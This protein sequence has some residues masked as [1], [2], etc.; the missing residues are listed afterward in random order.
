M[1]LI[2]TGASKLAH[3]SLGKGPN[4][5]FI[6]GWPLHSETWRNIAP[7]LAESF[8]CHLFDLPGA[9]RSEW[10]AT[11]PMTLDAHARAVVRAIDKL[12][13]ERVAFVAHDSGGVVARIAAAELGRRCSA[14]VFGNS[15]IAGYRPPLLQA[16]VTLLKM[17]GGAW[18]LPRALR[19]KVMRHSNFGFGGCFGD[20]SLIDGE[21]SELFIKPLFLSHEGQLGLARDF[22]WGVLDRLEAT[23]KEITAPVHMLWGEGDPWFPVGRARA[24]KSQFPGGATFQEL[25]GKLFTHEE[26]PALWAQHART[27]LERVVPRELV[28]HA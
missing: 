18:L 21:F 2:D 12:G 26:N 28:N 14:L 4:V 8:T 15:E 10:S 3:R 16:L 6:H 13:L 27:F 5:V 7:A 19:L 20:K 17:P 11:T 9:G 24:M 23:H 22:D 25:P 1:N